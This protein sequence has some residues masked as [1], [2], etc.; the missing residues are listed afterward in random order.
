[1]DIY[2][3]AREY[4]QFFETL[5]SGTTKEKYAKIVD[6]NVYFEDPFHNTYGLEAFIDVFERMFE[7]VD[8]PKFKV[9]EIVANENIAYL[10][11]VFSCEKNSKE[12]SFEGLS[13][14]AFAS[15]G[16]VITHVDFWDAAKNVYS[17]V[18]ILGSV[19]R[20]IQRKIQ[21]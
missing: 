11:W 15:N 6:E 1:M 3:N 20:Y 8:V 7:S 4:A 21:G 18:P 10:R 16:K 12:Y 14:A 2:E 9:E 13:R 17:H 19:L 5:Q